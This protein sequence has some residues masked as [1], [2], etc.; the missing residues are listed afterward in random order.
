MVVLGREVSLALSVFRL[1]RARAGLKTY[2][3]YWNTKSRK[4]M[5]MS[6]S[7][8]S[9]MA[10]SLL[11]LRRCCSRLS[12]TSQPSL[13][14]STL[15]ANP[16]RNQ[17]GGGT[18]L[19]LPFLLSSVRH[20]A[21]RAKKWQGGRCALHQ[22]SLFMLFPFLLPSKLGFRICTLNP[23][24][25]HSIVRRVNLYIVDCSNLYKDLE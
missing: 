1:F 13:S 12:L 10:S 21:K 5:A 7:S 11:L 19:P 14:P 3:H 22:V 24:P 8:S 9:A 23:K 17:P 25:L 2:V 20:Y 15:A 4:A 18:N 6:S 16:A